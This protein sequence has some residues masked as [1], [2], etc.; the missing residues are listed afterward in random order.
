[1][2][3]YYHGSGVKHRIFFQP[4]L[5]HPETSEWMEP[6]DKDGKIKPKMFDVLFENHVADVDDKLGKYLIANGF[7][8]KTKFIMPAA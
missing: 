3:V 4:G 5:D 8:S 7:A 6:A 1:M 2:K